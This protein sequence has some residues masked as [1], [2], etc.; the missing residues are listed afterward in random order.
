MLTLHG[1]YVLGKHLKL[2]FLQETLQNL[3]N[4]VLGRAKAKFTQDL[5][6]ESCLES[7]LGY[8]HLM[9]DKAV[10]YVKYPTG[11]IFPFTRDLDMWVFYMKSLFV[12]KSKHKTVNHESICLFF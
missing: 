12:F 7:T 1:C 6:V 2:L 3:I 11:Q 10:Y 4:K 5:V 9:K 8:I